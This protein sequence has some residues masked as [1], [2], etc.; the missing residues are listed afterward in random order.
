MQPASL[1]HT[2]QQGQGPATL[3]RA[4]AETDFAR[5]HP[6]AQVLLG[7]IIGERQGWV[8]QHRPDSSPIIEKFSGQLAGFRVRTIAVLRALELEFFQLVSQLLLEICRRASASPV[9]GFH[10]E[11][12]PRD[13]FHSEKVRFPLR[14]IR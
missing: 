4:C 6:V 11:Q 2:R 3:F 5:N 1:N 14:T 13:Y 9:D 12:P 8:F 7:K 10:E